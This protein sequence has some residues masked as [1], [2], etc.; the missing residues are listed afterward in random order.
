MKSKVMITVLSLAF[1]LALAAPD[2][3]RA[4]SLHKALRHIAQDIKTKRHAKGLADDQKPKK[5][6]GSSKT[7]TF[8]LA[9]KHGEGR[10]SDSEYCFGYTLKCVAEIRKPMNTFSGRVS[11]SGGGEVKFKDMKS[12]TP[13]HV[14]L[15]T[16]FFGDTTF[17][18]HLKAQDQPYPDKIKVHLKCSY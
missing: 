12:G 7:V 17:K 8:T 14:T 18:V 1:A 15:G 3:A 6:L 10:D 11:S 5:P 4:G 9:L 13:L 16:D 2:L